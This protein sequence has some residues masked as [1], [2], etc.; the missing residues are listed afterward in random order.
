MQGSSRPWIELMH[1]ANINQTQTIMCSKFLK[2]Y[3]L[4]VNPNNPRKVDDFK[5]A[6]P[7]G[8]HRPLASYPLIL[9][10]LGMHRRH[11]Q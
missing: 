6:Y 4:F 8:R 11:I 10:S 9:V 7:E 3:L 2:S 1:Q 5:V